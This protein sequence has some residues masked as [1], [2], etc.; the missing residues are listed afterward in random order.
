LKISHT[1]PLDSWPVCFVVWEGSAKPRIWG[2]SPLDR[3]WCRHWTGHTWL[4]AKMRWS[5][6]AWA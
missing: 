4:R 6:M 3:A 2:L 5:E 1:L